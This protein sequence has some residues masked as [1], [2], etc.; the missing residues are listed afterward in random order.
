M[1]LKIAFA[2]CCASS[3]AA[4][5][6][7]PPRPQCPNGG[8]W[9]MW[10]LTATENAETPIFAGDRNTRTATVC[11]CTESSTAADAG[12]WVV[13]LQPDGST[14]AGRVFGHPLLGMRVFGA[15]ATPPGQQAPTAPPPPSIPPTAGVD[16]YYLQGNACTAVGPGSVILR[17]ADHRAE[18]WGVW[19]L[20]K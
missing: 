11:N 15:S 12:V 6:D 16:V 14:R 8:D 1:K 3:F 19:K 13:T 5:A 4:F 7:A 20:D 17:T 18:K 2:A 9:L 10:H